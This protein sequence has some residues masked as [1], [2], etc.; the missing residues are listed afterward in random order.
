M[1]KLLLILMALLLTFSLIACGDDETT[2]TESSPAT[3]DK[4]DCAVHFDADADG[5]C[6][7]CGETT[8]TKADSVGTVLADAIVKQFGEAQ[9]VTLEVNLRVLMEKTEWSD[10]ETE[11]LDY[12]DGIAKIIITAAKTEKGCNLK[13]DVDVKSKEAADDEY[14]VTQSGTVIYLV[15]G[16]VYQYDEEL[17]QY[18]SYELSGVDSEAIAEAERMFNEIFSG[19]EIPEEEINAVINQLGAAVLTSFNI[20]ENMGS[21]TVDLKPVLDEIKAYITAID[22]DTTTVGDILNDLLGGATYEDVLLA[23][24]GA[25]SMTVSQ[26]VEYANTVLT[27]TYGM[28]INEFY[29]S[30]M[31]NEQLQDVLVNVLV[32]TGEFDEADAKAAVAAYAALEITDMIPE[33]MMD[34]VVYDLIMMM[35]VGT[36][37]DG[38]PYEYDTLEET[39]AMAREFLELTV[40]EFAELIELDIPAEAF[41]TLLGGID[42]KAFNSKLDVKFKGAFQVEYIEG[43][44]VVDVEAVVPSGYADKTNKVNIKVT[45]NAKFYNIT[46]EKTEITAPTNVVV[47]EDVF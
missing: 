47:D 23:A 46:T 19:V 4:L 40:S 32:A 9:S 14:E 26:L 12:V 18:Y 16:V 28:N 13:V 30:I 25:L 36:D 33:E 44:S 34:V 38:V 27:E 11:D 6:D 31:A 45:F 35:V 10:A 43:A 20:K 41:I 3:E 29:A 39:M 24:E 42:V 17:E 5:K 8:E 22:P 21:I 1:K 7:N 2:P 37:E 15:D